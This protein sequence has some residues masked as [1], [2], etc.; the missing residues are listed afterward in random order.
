M[1]Q[2]LKPLSGR[3]QREGERNSAPF[4]WRCIDLRQPRQSLQQ[5]DFVRI[6]IPDTGNDS[7]IQQDRI[8]ITFGAQHGRLESMKIDAPIDYVRP[9]LAERDHRPC[10]KIGLLNIG[11][12]RLQFCL[13]MRL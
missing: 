9:T 2:R 5:R 12:D 4:G 6:N 1:K 3:G 7:L 8:D 10:T 13:L 11:V